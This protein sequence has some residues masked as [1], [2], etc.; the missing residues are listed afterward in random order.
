VIGR[1]AV[2]LQDDVPANEPSDLF[3][4]S[5]F[6]RRGVNLSHKNAEPRTFVLEYDQQGNGFLTRGREITVSAHGTQWV[7]LSNEPQASWVRVTCNQPLTKATA[8]FTGSNADRRTDQPDPIF[9]GVAEAEEQGMTGGIVRARGENKRTLHFV[10][11]E[12][13]ESGPREVG[14]YELDGALNLSRVEDAAALNYQKQRA[15]IP[16]GVLTADAASIVFVDDSNRRWRLP[17]ASDKFL[18]DGP[19]GPSRVCREVATERDLFNAGGTFF[20]L[21][22][23]N[24]GG[25]ANVRAVAT[26]NRRVVDFCSY[27]GLFVMS[28][29]SK[30]AP[31]ENSHIVRSD[32]GKAALWVGAI[33]DVW[34]FGK[35]RG[36]GG[37]WKDTPVESGV[38]SDPYLLTG[39]DRRTVDFSAADPVRVTLEVDISGT[40]QWVSCHVADVL[41]DQ[42]VKYQLPEA[43][44]GYWIRA[45]SCVDTTATVQLRYE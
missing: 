10:A 8:W 21:P 42:T 39:Y 37:P 43:L 28:G 26:H 2:W 41:P 29:I 4:F 15:A 31:L 17:R 36:V 40:G 9:A 38:P 6:E 24:A 18:G 16:A 32:D 14:L 11:Q 25:F 3:L 7:D 45:I 35:P 22:A 13:S 44:S 34:K 20:E 12:A 19:L 23:E 33:D 30:T 5:G 27:R 1:G